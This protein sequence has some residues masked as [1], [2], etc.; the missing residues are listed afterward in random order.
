MAGLGWAYWP[1][2]QYL[3]TIWDN[4]PNYSHGILVIPIA[5][6][7]FLQR[8]A[9]VKVGWNVSRGPWWSWVVLAAIVAARAFA[10]ER[11]SQWLETATVVPAVASLMFTLG[12]WPLLE[13]G[14]PAVVFLLFMLNLPTAINNMV[15]MPLQRIATM[16]SVFVMQLTG[17]WVVTEGNVIILRTPLPPPNDHKLLEVALACNGLSMLMTLA[18]TVT[19][20]IVLIPLANWKRIVVLASAIPIALLSN[21]IRIVATG[22][23]Y[24]YIEGERGKKFAHD[25]SG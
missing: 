14:W 10:Y 24:Y 18:A 23:C 19:A 15:A 22:W 9:D 7:I 21:I 4:E 3:Y 13:R 8:L 6:V 16:G 12:G 20:T 5:L 1:N 2:L 25:W 17:L 11:G